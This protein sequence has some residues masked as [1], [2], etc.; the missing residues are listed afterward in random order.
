MYIQPNKQVSKQKNSSTNPASLGNR[1]HGL[2]TSLA[3]VVDVA[4]GCIADGAVGGCPQQ[5][6]HSAVQNA[7]APVAACDSGLRGRTM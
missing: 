4:A 3:P 7:C 6:P 1:L 2:D 5:R